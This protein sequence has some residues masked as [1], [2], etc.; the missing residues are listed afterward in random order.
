MNQHHECRKV[1]YATEKYALMDAE[2]IIKKNR[3]NYVVRAYLCSF[4]NFWHFTARPAK[5]QAVIATLKKTIEEKDKTIADMKAI[6]GKLK[7]S[8]HVKIQAE[9]KTD[10]KIV[11][12]KKGYKTKE[13]RHNKLRGDVKVL[14][15][16]I[17]NLQRKLDL[18]TN[19]S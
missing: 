15:E 11:N 1:Q 5:E 19:H 13:A 10:E 17:I 6:I 2:E 3:Q 9:I 14:V 12:L 4:C 18:L 7:D 8:N 16:R